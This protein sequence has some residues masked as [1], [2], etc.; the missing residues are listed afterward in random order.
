MKK[1]L[2]VEKRILMLADPAYSENDEDFGEKF[3]LKKE[4]G[5]GYIQK[6]IV[7]SSIHIM[8]SQ[9]ALKRDTILKRPKKEG[10]SGS[11]NIITFSFRNVKNKPSVMVS[12]ADMDLEITTLADTFTSNIII[13]VHAD[14][15]K[16]LI[17]NNKA[18]SLWKTIIDGK[19]PFI[20]EELGSSEIQISAI[21]MIEAKNPKELSHF[22]YRIKSEELI[23]LFFKLFLKRKEVQNYPLN[24]SDIKRIYQIRDRIAADLTIIPNLSELVKLHSISESKMQR[25]FK[26]IFGNT[27]YNYHQYLRIREAARL[28]KEDKISV[29]EV[30]Y[31]LNFSNMSHFSRVF[32]KYMG[33]NP[34]KYSLNNI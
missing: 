12:S 14:F 34:K 6:I 17:D 32:K 2:L 31:H 23:F 7:G 1:D 5:N 4:I 26:Q 33:E 11:K 22:Y 28:L 21:S 25:I 18:D 30:G 29:S 20:Y 9:Y 3:I 16:G 8:I 10:L 27:I 24:E 15:L 19:K 13:T